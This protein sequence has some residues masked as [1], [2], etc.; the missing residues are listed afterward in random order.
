MR[1]FRRLWVLFRPHRGAAAAA[2]AAMLGVS[3]FTAVVAYLIGP[4]FDQVVSPANKGAVAAALEKD[5]SA[6]KLAG[7][8]GGT[9]EARRTPVIRFLDAGFARV[10]AAAG[11][12]PANQAL[13][14][15]LFVFGAFLAKNLCQFVAEYRFNAVGLAFVRDLRSGLYGRLLG[16]SGSFHARHPSGDLIARVTGDVGRIQ[17]LFGTDLADLVQPVATL[18]ALG[19]LVVSR[20]PELT[21]VASSS[22]RRSSCRSS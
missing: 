17:S 14:I 21:G 3:L 10:L 8:L 4:L 19:L 16:Q 6:G 9:Q 1:D 2:I 15:P 11:G 13:L 12:T 22:P 7:V 5:P 18:A 20:S